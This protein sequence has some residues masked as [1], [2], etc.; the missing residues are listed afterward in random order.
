MNRQSNEVIPN[1]PVTRNADSPRAHEVISKGPELGDFPAYIIANVIRLVSCPR[2]SIDAEV[3]TNG[4]VHLLFPV[5]FP[6]LVPD[7]CAL[8]DDSSRFD[9]LDRG[10]IPTN[11]DNSAVYI[12]LLINHNLLKPPPIVS[13]RGISGVG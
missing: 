13:Y 12:G 4:L 7:L 2:S 1:T 11:R 10:E 9:H 8:Y 5:L 6:D 3:S